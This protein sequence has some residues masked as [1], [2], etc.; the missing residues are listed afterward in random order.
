MNAGMT[1][2]QLKSSE[3][4]PDGSIFPVSMGDGTG[5]KKVTKETLVTEIGKDLKIGDLNDLKTQDKTS[6]VEAINEAA[7]L[8]VLDTKEEIEANTEAGKIA[9]AQAVKEMVG[10][11]NDNLSNLSTDLY[12]FGQ[13]VNIGAVTSYKATNNCLVYIQNT[14]KNNSFITFKVND[15]TAFTA[16]N[17]ATTENS[18]LRMPATLYMS[19]GDILTIDIHGDAS[20]DF[21]KIVKMN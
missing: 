12:K 13:Q 3:T 20:V 15:L 8:D 19:K 1:F 18:A 11:L 17:G 10:E 9:G 16:Q 7:T 2:G 4:I 5:S 6:L 21:V 14:L